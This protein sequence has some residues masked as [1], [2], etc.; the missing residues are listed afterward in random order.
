[1]ELE[2]TLLRKVGEA[3]HRFKMIRDGDRVA[4]ALSGGK[5]SITLLEAL[6]LLAKRAPIDFSVCA[7]TV[8]QG[9]FLRPIQPL[10]EYLKGRGVAW[11]Y[12]RDNPSLKLLEEQPTHGCDLCSRYRRRAVYEICSGLGAN[13]I[14][15]GHTAD[16]FCE[17]LLRNTLFTGRL[18]ALPPVTLSRDR[19]F[20]LIRP[21][22]F[23][24]EEITRAYAEALAV[25]VVPCDCSLRTGTVRRSLR[26]MFS[27]LEKEYPHL[28]ENMLSAMGNV[29]TQRLLD[30]RLLDMEMPEETPEPFPIL[31]EG[32]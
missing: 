32:D 15:F 30:P 8:E 11:T 28:K 6:L 18:S 27:E 5:D 10:G 21:L 12:F 14:A 23:V 2:K 1:V 22:V 24:T 17:A 3:I 20:R 31:T 16:D 19:Q 13:V 29:D 9:K 25:P 7:F 26:G 4:V